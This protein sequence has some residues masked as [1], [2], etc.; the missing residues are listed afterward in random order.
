MNS[1]SPLLI[2]ILTSDVKS[3]AIRARRLA[4]LY[5]LAGVLALGGIAA[6]LVSGGFYLARRMSPEAAA[7]VIA[8]VLLAFSLILVASAMIWSSRQRRNQTR[9]SVGTAIAA[10]AAV[11]L[12]PVLLSN[13]MAFGIISAAVAGFV[14]ANRKP[15]G[16]TKSVPQNA[17]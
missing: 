8:G 6:L 2:G 4:I 10:T 7:L 13:R 9:R 15:S 16:R 1:L 12:L 5:G 14:Y 3:V 17:D 11:S